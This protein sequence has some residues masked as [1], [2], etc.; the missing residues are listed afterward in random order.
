[1]KGMWMR[2]YGLMSLMSTCVLML[3]SKS[4]GGGGLMGGSEREEGVVWGAV[5]G[6]GRRGESS[7]RQG[8]C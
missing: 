1:M 2:V 6:K 3:R 8:K 5:R 4:G 7:G